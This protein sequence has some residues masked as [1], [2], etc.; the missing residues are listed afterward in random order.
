MK[1]RLRKKVHRRLLEYVVG[2]V[3][4]RSHWRRLLYSGAEGLAHRIDAQHCEAL[5]AW[6][7]RAIR[8]YQLSYRV[9]VVSGDRAPGWGAYA[10][11]GLV[12]FRFEAREFPEV[13]DFSAN[14][15]DVV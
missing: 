5:P 6:L 14:N 11:D 7:V 2:E 10:A 9:R 1:R 3:S 12:L 8:R 13:H 4:Q 15:P